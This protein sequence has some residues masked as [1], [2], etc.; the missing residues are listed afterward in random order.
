MVLALPKMHHV[1][2]VVADIEAAAADF[3]RRWGVSIEDVRDYVTTDA[4][5]QG[6]RV[7]FTARFGFIRTGGAQIE[8]I[9]PVEGRS[10]YTDF[11][12]ANHGDGVH[13]LAY[14]VESIDAYL[15][16]LTDIGEPP[17]IQLDVPFAGS[18]RVIYIEHVAHGP[19]IELVEMPK[20]PE[21]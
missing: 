4:P 6:G 17:S 20:A 15:Q 21:Q 5:Y 10:P 16:Q 18:G 13:H 11:L 12:A 19:V 14:I 3:Q 9:Q 7:T 1:A 2:I 8:V